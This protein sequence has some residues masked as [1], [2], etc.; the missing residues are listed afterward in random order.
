MKTVISIIIPVYNT[1]NYLREC[2]ESVL[3]QSFSD[4]ELLLIDDGS[5]DCS[6]E[7]CQEYKAKDKRIRVFQKQNSGVSD[8]RNMGLD[9]AKGEYVSFCDSDDFIDKEMYQILYETMIKNNVDRVCGGYNYVYEN[10]RVVRCK[11]RISDGRYTSKH[12]IKRMIDDGTLSG[13]LFSGVNNSLFKRSIIEKYNVRFNKK[14]K[15]NEDSLF[16][17]SYMI[18]SS[19]IYALQSKPLYYYR[20]YASSSTGKRAIGDMYIPFR[21]AL[22]NSNI[23]KTILDIQMKR[24]IITETLWQILDISKKEKGVYA[25]KRI[26]ALLDREEFTNNTFVINPN[27][28]NR[29]KRI[30]FFLMKHRLAWLLYIISGKVVPIA[31]KYLSR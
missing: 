19:S 1:S 15:Y 7:I 6:Y 21:E 31:S 11:P 25:V 30:Y 13:V 24:R 28:L 20:Q 2:I 12:I 8:T 4:F 27:A 5:T 3:N 14:V 18:N 26:K 16:S 22:L 9:H 17:I 10:N 23:D 29:Y